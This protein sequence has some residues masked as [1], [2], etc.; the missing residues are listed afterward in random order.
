[1][2]QDDDESTANEFR[3][4]LDIIEDR[5]SGVVIDSQRSRFFNQEQSIYDLATDFAY[6]KKSDG[7][8]GG[9]AKFD[10]RGSGRVPCMSITLGG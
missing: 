2:A 1:M 10:F 8:R 4:V 3:A 6:T 9:S 5:R 7:T